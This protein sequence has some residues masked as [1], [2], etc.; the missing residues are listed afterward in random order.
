MPYFRSLVLMVIVHCILV[1]FAIMGKYSD[2]IIVDSDDESIS[3][4]F[5]IIILRGASRCGHRY[6]MSFEK[7]GWPS[8]SAFGFFSDDLQKIIKILPVIGGNDRTLAVECHLAVDPGEDTSCFADADERG[9]V[10]PRAQVDLEI[11]VDGAVG[12]EAQ[13]VRRSADTS[14]VL[15]YRVHAFGDPEASRGQFLV[16]CAPCRTQDR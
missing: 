10:I 12:E 14:Y 7:G 8:D 4:Q 15:A 9:S 16:V 1:A 2:K 6:R 11:Q 5:H 13:F 3:Y